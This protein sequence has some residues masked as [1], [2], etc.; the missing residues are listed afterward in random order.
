VALSQRDLGLGE[1]LRN[2]ALIH[3]AVV[4]LAPCSTALRSVGD[5]GRG[6]LER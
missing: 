3:Q 5:W 4:A 6:T 1:A 2:F